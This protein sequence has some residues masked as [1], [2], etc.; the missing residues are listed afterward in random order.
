VVTDALEALLDDLDGHE[1]VPYPSLTR[2]E[3][4]SLGDE[5][6]L[7]DTDDVEWLDRLSPGTRAEVVATAQR[8][9]VARDLVSARDAETLDVDRRVRMIL[10]LRR[11]PAFVTLAGSASDH[12]VFRCYGVLGPDGTA[13]VLVEVRRMP[14]VGE[15]RLCT[16][17][18]AAGVVSRFLLTPSPGRR[19]LEMFPPGSLTHGERYFVV[20]P[21]TLRTPSG[22]ESPATP[23]GLAELITARWT[24]YVLAS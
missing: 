8:G 22:Q 17:R 24:G 9:L 4:L 2:D 3:L 16:P 15:Y 23:G 11:V 21:G 5:P 20:P 14:G 12:P 10:A 18:Y 13:A 19:R 6:L 7:L 1:S